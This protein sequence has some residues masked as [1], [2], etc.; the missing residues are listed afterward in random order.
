MIMIEIV[1]AKHPTPLMEQC[2]LYYANVEFEYGYM[3]LCLTPRETLVITE[4][5]LNIGGDLSPITFKIGSPIQIRLMGR[6]P[7]QLD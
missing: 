4:T 5:L 1:G 7:Y 3:I 6:S 2:R